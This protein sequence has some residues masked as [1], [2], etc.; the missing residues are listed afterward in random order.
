MA[1][2]NI[3]KKSQGRDFNCFYR[4][5]VNWSSFGGGDS[6][7][8]SGPDVVIS[9]KTQGVILA[10]EGSGTIEYSLNGNTSH[11]EL[12]SGGSRAQLQFNNRNMSLIWFRVKTGSSG[13]INVS[14][15]AW[16]Q[17]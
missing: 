9:F 13:P 4:V 5:A 15:E 16:A 7:N 17:E 14:V 6:V 12:I 1:Y 8:N 11:G 2:S 3:G 10:I